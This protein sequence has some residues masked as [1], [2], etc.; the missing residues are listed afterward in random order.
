M[1]CNEKFLDILVEAT[2]PDLIRLRFNEGRVPAIHL[3][4]QPQHAE[5]T[6][7]TPRSNF[8]CTT[9]QPDRRE[10]SI[11]AGKHVIWSERCSIKMSQG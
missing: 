2:F 6:G 3:D 7:E 9:R 8:R 10:K 1:E 5:R 4:Y 11:C